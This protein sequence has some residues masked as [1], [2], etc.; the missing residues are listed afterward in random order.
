MI[1]FQL[2]NNNPKEKYDFYADIIKIRTLIVI[3]FFVPIFIRGIS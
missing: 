3:L 1:R 2:F